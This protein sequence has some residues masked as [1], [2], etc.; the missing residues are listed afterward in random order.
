ME[1]FI[2]IIVVLIIVAL[3]WFV[4]DHIPIAS[5]FNMFIKAVA[6]LGAIFYLATRYLH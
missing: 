2:T 6:A 1:P 3:V 4:V 5:P